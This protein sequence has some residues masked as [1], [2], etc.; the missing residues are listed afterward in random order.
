MNKLIVTILVSMFLISSTISYA[1]LKSKVVAGF[2]VRLLVKAIKNPK[3]QANIISKVTSN[4]ILKKKVV[5][6]LEKIILNPKHSNIKNE[7]SSFLAKIKNIKPI[8][9]PTVKPPSRAPPGVATINGK[10]PMNSKLAG[11]TL[12]NGV[13][14]NSRGFPDFSPHAKNTVKIDMK[15]NRT[16][17]FKEAN[18]QAGYDK[19]PD[20]YTWHHHEDMKTMELVPKDLHNSTPHSGGVWGIKNGGKYD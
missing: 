9:N 16:T 14:Y 17:D 20:G 19:T 4:P 2:G 6:N 15:G 3:L 1:G 5:E 10:A 7:S 11:Q 8:N 12:S 18:K 13:K